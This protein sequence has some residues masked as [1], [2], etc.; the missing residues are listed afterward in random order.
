MN[1]SL[2]FPAHWAATVP[3]SAL[4]A[5]HGTAGLVVTPWTPALRTSRPHYTATVDKHASMAPQAT[6]TPATHARAAAGL[7]H[8]EGAGDGA[9]W[10]ATLVAHLPHLQGLPAGTPLARDP[11]VLTGEEA[12]WLALHCG[13]LAVWSSSQSWSAHRCGSSAHTPLA[14]PAL[15]SALQGGCPDFAV[16]LWVYCASRSL[17]WVTRHGGPF[18]GQWVAYP[19]GPAAG[20]APFTLLA[21]SRPPTWRRVLSAH[22]VSNSVRKSLVL[23]HVPAAATPAQALAAST[24]DGT[25]LRGLHVDLQLSLTRRATLQK[26]VKAWLT[27]CAGV[28]QGGTGGQPGGKAPVQHRVVTASAV[29]DWPAVHPPPTGAGCPPVAHCSA[30]DWWPSYRT[31]LKQGM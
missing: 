11:L 28:Q 26:K 14:P 5:L 7:G 29:D 21:V 23:C 16:R 30:S 17:G 31:W 20:H 1:Q 6:W 9:T 13:V 2:N 18:A 4:P 22:R 8:G 15:L 10:S 3:A 12:A 27:T 19:D 24:L 25:M